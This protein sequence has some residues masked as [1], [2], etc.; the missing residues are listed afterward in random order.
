MNCDN[1]I[2]RQ[3]RVGKNGIPVHILKIK[4]MNGHGSE[5]PPDDRLSGGFSE[6]ERVNLIGAIL[7]YLAIDEI[8]QV[9]NL[10]RGDIQILGLRLLCK[11]DVDKLPEDIRDY[12]LEH[13]PSLI[14]GDLG[15]GSSGGDSDARY[16]YM[17]EFIKMM[18]DIEHVK[19]ASGTVKKNILFFRLIISACVNRVKDHVHR[20]IIGKKFF[21]MF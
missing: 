12:Y 20:K 17:S 8:P 15:I 18:N 4:T 7:R 2:F 14:A 16:R 19:G 1:F 11:A 9:I 3:E 21:E 13:T 5:T 10:V 6:I